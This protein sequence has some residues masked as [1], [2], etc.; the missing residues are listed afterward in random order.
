[1]SYSIAIKPACYEDILNLP[2]NIV[3]EILNG[4]LETHPRPAPKHALAASSIG[5]ELE[6]PF[7]KG[8]GGPGGWWILDEPECHIEGETFVPDLAG[9]RKERLP[10]MPDTAW[11]EVVPDWACE[12]I[13]PSSVR[14]DRVTKMAIYAQLQIQYL[15]LIDPLA[16]T[17]EAYQL[18][19]GHWLLLKSYAEDDS[20][21]IAPFAEHT[22]SLAVLWG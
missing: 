17:L 11:F 19:D 14:R 18:Q 1:M 21:S 2:E 6:N 16:Q 3:G 10:K 13:S 7:Q 5:G 4:K 15:W 12:V 8:R 20:V 9:W 22:F